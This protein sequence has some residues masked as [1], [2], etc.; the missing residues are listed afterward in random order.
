MKKGKKN[1]I[2]D[3]TSSIDKHGES[4]LKVAQIAAVQQENDRLLAH[5]SSITPRIATLCDLKRNLN[6]RLASHE[7]LTN[8]A[9]HDVIMKEVETIDEEINENNLNKLK[10]S[11]EE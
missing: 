1:Y 10:N 7:V 8:N 6:I 11:S 3:L 2:V 9:L 4:L 5:E